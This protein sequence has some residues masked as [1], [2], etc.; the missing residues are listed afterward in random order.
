M[1]LQKLDTK[2]TPRFVLDIIHGCKD[3]EGREEEDDGGGLSL[4]SSWRWCMPLERD[5]Q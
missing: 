1:S 4:A 5:E 2:V 3:K